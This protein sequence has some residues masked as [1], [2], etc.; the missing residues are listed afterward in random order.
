MDT[1]QGRIF[2]PQTLHKYLYNHADPVN[3]LDPSGNISL[4]QVAVSIGIAATLATAAV[5]TYGALDK[6][7]HSYSII[8]AICSIGI[9]GGDLCTEEA[10]FEL[11]RRFPAPSPPFIARAEPVST[12]GTSFAFPFGWVTHTVDISGTWLDNVTVENRH[13]LHPGEVHRNVRVS[14]SQIQ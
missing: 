13:L 8:T 14:G 9:S 4:S 5:V 12:G 7:P 3:R 11:L 10:V 6:R 2:E 1:F